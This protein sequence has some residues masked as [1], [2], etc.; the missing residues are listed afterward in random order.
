[1]SKKN[2][3]D[4][5]SKRDNGI[6][7]KAAY[8]QVR[9]KP[10]SKKQEQAIDTIRKNHLNFVI[11]PAGSSKSFLLCVSALEL[12]QK[13][14]VNKV[15]LVRPAV[16]AGKSLGYLPG[17]QEEKM[18]PY[19]MPLYENMFKIVDEFVVQGMF[20]TGDLE[21]LSPTLARGRTLDKA[22]V[23]VDEAQ[24]LNKEHLRMILTR[25]GEGTYYGVTM[26]GAQ[27]DIRPENSCF[28]DLDI[29]RDVDGIGFVEFTNED[30]VRSPLAKLVMD[31]Y[32]N[33]RKSGG[34]E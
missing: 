4:R 28:N 5:A 26:D 25:A 20:E 9:F 8:T 30:I 34:V 31:V 33:A 22:F 2:R 6:D 13:G 10:R 16:E 12:Y 19:L 23:I 32:D 17:T 24:N 3:N 15:V 21:V 1:M 18:H 14:L 29:F 11:G 27:I 7:P